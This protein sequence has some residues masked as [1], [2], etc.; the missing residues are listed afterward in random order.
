MKGRWRFWTRYLSVFAV[1]FGWHTPW[2]RGC[3]PAGQGCRRRPWMA[4]GLTDTLSSRVRQPGLSLL[5]SQPGSGVSEAAAQLPP[6][7]RAQHLCVELL[8]AGGGSVEPTQTRPETGQATYCH[9]LS[10]LRVCQPCSACSHWGGMFPYKHSELVSC[11]V[12]FGLK[13]FFI[14]L[15]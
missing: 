5:S 6:L 1:P 3:F 10:L 4:Q 9:L 12:L 7:W 11:V 15:Y 2:C 14:W 13:N 8:Q